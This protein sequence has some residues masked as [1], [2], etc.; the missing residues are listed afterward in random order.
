VPTTTTT[1][2]RHRKAK[3]FCLL[4]LQCL[5]KSVLT[6]LGF[7]SASTPTL[8][9]PRSD[10]HHPPLLKK[11][12]VAQQ[13]TTSSSDRGVAA[14]TASS[15]HRTRGGAPLTPPDSLTAS[16]ND[17]T[18]AVVA[19]TAVPPPQ[20]RSATSRNSPAG[21]QPSPSSGPSSTS[22]A[23]VL[24][25]VMLPA[26]SSGRGVPPAPLDAVGGEGELKRQQA[27]DSCI[28]GT[29][30]GGS[31]GSSVI[32]PNGDKP[33]NAAVSLL[34]LQLTQ[35]S[36]VELTSLA[37]EMNTWSSPSV[38]EAQSLFSVLRSATFLAQHRRADAEDDDRLGGAM[39]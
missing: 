8:I 36:I 21:A 18:T 32:G 9:S 7:S 11:A 28:M 16:L 1:T 10:L 30:V 3:L 19:A 12:S 38:P 13:K 35:P 14:S 34:C 37:L 17:A 27:S 33:Q 15:H 20:I 39:A 23:N 22:A 2:S 6:Q 5:K 24:S 29:G 26:P 25:P 4:M 31:S